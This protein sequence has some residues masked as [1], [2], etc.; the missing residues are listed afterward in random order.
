MK[1]IYLYSSAIIFSLFLIII[2]FHN[3]IINLSLPLIEDRIKNQLSLLDNDKTTIKIET[4]FTNNLIILN[5]YDP[6][7]KSNTYIEKGKAKSVSIEKNIRSI[8]NNDIAKIIFNDL[9]LIIKNNEILT[10]KKDEDIFN[11]IRHQVNNAIVE[12]KKFDTILIKNSFIDLD[13][14]IKNHE[15]SLKNFYINNKK[16]IIESRGLLINGNSKNS[17]EIRT[18]EKNNLLDLK[19]SLKE[20]SPNFLKNF[21]EE[22]TYK[23]ISKNIYTGEINIR[24]NIDLEYL[25]SN[26][27]IFAKNDEISAVGKYNSKDNIH[28]SKIFIKNIPLAKLITNNQILNYIDITNL[29]NVNV[30]LD[31]LKNFNNLNYYI[32]SLDNNFIVRGSLK[33]NINYDFNLK[34]SDFLLDDYILNKKIFSPINVSNLGELNIE[35]NALDNFNEI[36]FNLYNSNDNF[37]VN[38]LWIDDQFQ[39]FESEGINF[40]FNEILNKNTIKIQNDIFNNFIDNNNFS[41]NFNYKFEN[42]KLEINIEDRYDNIATL[43]YDI[44]Q[45][46]IDKLKLNFF[47]SD[48][49]EF[50]LN[51]E[52]KEFRLT[53]D[54]KLVE[55]FQ[56]EFGINIFS[57]MDIKYI[58]DFEKI[59]FEGKLVD[60][61]LEKIEKLTNLNN[62]VEDFSLY[63]E[64]SSI[65]LSN[66]KLIDE[67]VKINGPADILFEKNH[68]NNSNRIDI[69]FSKSKIEIE[70]IKFLK[71]PEKPLSLSFNY[72]NQKNDNIHIDNLHIIGDDILI[73]ANITLNNTNIK[74]IN[75][76]DFKL[77]E[78]DFNLTLSSNKKNS[79]NNFNYSLDIGGKKLDISFLDVKKTKS[80]FKNILIK[81]KI[82]V[83]KLKYINDTDFSPAELNGTFF[84]VWQNLYFKGLFDTGEDLI[85]SVKSNQSNRDFIIESSNAS[86]TLKIKNITKSITGGSLKFTG[87]YNNNNDDFFNA[88]LSINNFAIKKKSKLA[89][90]IKVIRIFDIKKQ[91]DGDTEDFEYA[92]M[93][94]IK[95]NKIF[96]ISNGKAYGGLM[97]LTFDGSIDK[98]IDSLDIK[99]MVAPTHAIDSWVGQIPL[100]GTILTGLEGG[101]VVAANY[102]VTGAIKDPKYFVNPLSVLTP[103]IFKEFWKIFELPTAEQIN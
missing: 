68:T 24:T 46:K 37:F 62:I 64:K 41:F 12:L 92:E 53:F 30:E 49:N 90:F 59:N 19:I 81:V 56:K 47:N 76:S 43:N 83:K 85:I 98:N 52:L 84:N 1:K 88:K 18:L 17:F 38:G 31:I 102:N 91:L 95:N 78:N 51:D 80:L 69:N 99:G 39:K 14:S 44:E 71:L 72:L 28:K 97:A 63:I 35:I 103:G 16:N 55:F 87:Q 54:N 26:Y 8:F 2:I 61:Y 74:S 94:I 7:F 70:R 48:F 20:Y 58:K 3:K 77:L 67:F 9:N 96:N 33:N 5:I 82:N 93:K 73:K 57:E 45:Q 50:I 100:L 42:R 27:E 66:I 22:S 60:K 65:D 15:I 36:N 11:N 6:E 75:I 13:L 4:D 25:D 86:K 32:T 21:I 23:I 34:Y 10:N 101:G 89:T 29:G 79:N 40:K